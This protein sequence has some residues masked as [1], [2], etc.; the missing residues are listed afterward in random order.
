MPSD[1]SSFPHLL[2]R[3][4]LFILS[5]RRWGGWEGG[6]ARERSSGF[7]LWPTEPLWSCPKSQA[8]IEPKPWGS[9][10]SASK[11]ACTKYRDRSSPIEYREF[12][13]F[14]L[15]VLSLGV[16]FSILFYYFTALTEMGTWL[17]PNASLD[18]TNGDF[19]SVSGMMG[20]GTTGCCVHRGGLAVFPLCFLPSTLMLHSLFPI[21][22]LCPEFSSSWHACMGSSK[23]ICRNTSF[24]SF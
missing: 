16:V 7:F 1:L 6:R 18:Q 4:A 23:V 12:S 24:K 13:T 10:I 5:R 8:T 22:W 2:A 19:V 20:P 14:S 11:T 17:T 9:L 21:P 15:R 3:P